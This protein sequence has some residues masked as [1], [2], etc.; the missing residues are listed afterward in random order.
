[1]A[2]PPRWW[3]A[4]CRPRFPR[5]PSRSGARRSSRQATTRYRL[6]RVALR[7]QVHPDAPVSTSLPFD[8]EVEFWNFVPDA[9]LHVCLHVLNE[10]QIVAF[11]TA[12]NETDAATQD[13][14]LHAGLFRSVCRI[15]AHL[16]NTGLHRITVLVLLNGLK[17]VL[18]YD[19][20]LTFEVVETESR[21]GAW[22][23]REPGAVRPRLP[24]HTTR[25][26]PSDLEPGAVRVADTAGAPTE[27]RR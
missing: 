10:Q 6:R 15:P 27:T 12:S 18:R 25:V 1:M 23:G 20:A 9:R 13:R 17:I 24:W 3:V 11:T 7:A 16:L 21:P 22:Y 2:P 4:I 5:K 26:D 19:D 8:V 14:P